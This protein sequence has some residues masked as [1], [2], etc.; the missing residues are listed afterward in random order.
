MGEAAANVLMLKGLSQ[1]SEGST[2]G[3]RDYISLRRDTK[4]SLCFGDW[5]VFFF[6]K[7]LKSFPTAQ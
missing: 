5:K 3:W 2:A 4:H 6:L 1:N 7:K